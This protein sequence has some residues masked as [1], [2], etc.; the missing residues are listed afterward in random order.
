[1]SFEEE[2]SKLPKIYD[3]LE[4]QRSNGQVLI[5]ECEQHIGEHTVR[6]IAMDSTDGLSRGMKVTATGESNLNAGRRSN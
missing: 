5:L 4:V 3:A 6:T 2:S 1:M